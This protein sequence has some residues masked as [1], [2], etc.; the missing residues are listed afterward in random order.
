MAPSVECPNANPEVMRFCRETL[1]LGIDVASKA[2][3]VKEDV[4]VAIE[5]GESHPSLS[6]LRKMAD[7]YKRPI[8][9]FFLPSPPPAVIPPR[10]FRTRTGPLSAQ[11]LL[12]IRRAR[13]LQRNLKQLG[14]DGNVEFWARNDRPIVAAELARTWIG[15]THEQQIRARDSSEFFNLVITA[16]DQRAIQVLRLQFPATEAKAFCLGDSPKVIVVTTNDN[17]VGSRIF[18][19][20]HELGHLSLGESSICLTLEEQ[21]T[22]DIERYCD[23][24]ATE[25]LMPT[26]LISNLVGGLRGAA[27][28]DAVDDLADL[29]K[30]S[31]TALLIKFKQMDLID[32][33]ELQIKLAELRAR[34]PRQQQ[35]RSTRTSIVLKEQGLTLPRLVFGG[36]KNEVLSPIEASRFLNLNQGNLTEVGSRLGYL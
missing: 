19:T 34:N 7:K 27:L 36:L 14:M 6:M 12:A 33:D 21:S 17:V 1:N 29:V 20:F 8:A 4:L 24:F 35:G 15:I 11:I 26:R 18:S 10:D 28:A 5:S 30:S 2:L 16:L 22:N 13:N 3:D 31:K 32:E 23:L 9:T 25:L